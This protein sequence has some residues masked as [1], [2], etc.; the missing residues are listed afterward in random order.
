MQT[1]LALSWLTHFV[2][3]CVHLIWV[4]RVIRVIRVI[5]VIR[6]IRVIFI[7]V[8]VFLECILEASIVIIACL[9]FID[10]LRIGSPS[11][12]NQNRKSI[13]LHTNK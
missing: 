8:R 9:L 5:G 10:G 12:S 6:V 4:I 7:L 1:L 2:C 11:L 13:Y 3:L